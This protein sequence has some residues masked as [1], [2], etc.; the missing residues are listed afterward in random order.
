MFLS[1][2]FL[3]FGFGGTLGLGV[4]GERCGVA[5]SEISRCKGSLGGVLDVFPIVA[6]FSETVTWNIPA[7]FFW[8]SGLRTSPDDGN[9]SGGA[10]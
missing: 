6:S 2:S 8:V 4:P 1:T 9:T 10:G 7:S 5:L 3:L